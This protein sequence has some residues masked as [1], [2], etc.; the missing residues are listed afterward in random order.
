PN[1]RKEVERRMLAKRFSDYE[2]LAEWVRQQGYDISDD[3]LWRYGK[4]LKRE[5]TAARFSLLQARMLASQAPD[6]KGRLMQAL[7][8]VVQQRLLSALAEAE[9]TDHA[10]ISRLVHAVAELARV[11]FSHQRWTAEVRKRKKER[12]RRE[13]QAVIARDL[14]EI[15]QEDGGVDEPYGQECE[16]N[17]HDPNDPND[18][19]ILVA[20]SVRLPAPG[21]RSEK[22]GFGRAAWP[23]TNR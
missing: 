19:R 14:R 20:N 12:R 17:E 6:H 10:E 23:S 4:S 3:S 7:I 9:E 15:F 18:L 2:G 16:S 22:P 13:E 1:I 21:L 8:Q 11:S 5:F